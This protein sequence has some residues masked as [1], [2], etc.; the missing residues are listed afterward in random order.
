MIVKIIDLETEKVVTEYEV[1]KDIQERYAANEKEFKKLDQPYIPL[2]TP[3]YLALINLKDKSLVTIDECK[4]MVIGE[5]EL[6][7]DEGIISI[8]VEQYK[9]SK[10]KAKFGRR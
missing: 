2:V 3:E 5:Y 1:Y 8:Y 6:D 7:T 10:S 4:Y 9:V